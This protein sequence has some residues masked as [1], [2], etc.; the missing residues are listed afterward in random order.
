MITKRRWPW[1]GGLVGVVALGSGLTWLGL[2]YER[3]NAGTGPGEPA[4]SGAGATM[5]E[6]AVACF[7]HVDVKHG[8]TSLFPAQSG[9]VAEVLVEENQEV[10]AGTVLLRLEDT[11]SRLRVEEARADLEAARAQLVQTRKLPQQHQAQGAQAMAAIEVAQ[12]RLAS[13]RQVCDSKADLFAK[14]LL[15]HTE[16]DVARH[17]VKEAEAVLQAEQQKLTELKLHDAATDICR[18]EED[19]KARQARLGQALEALRECEL[20]APTDGKVLRI[21][22]GPGEMLGTRPG[23]AAI[24]FCPNGPRIIRAEVEQEFASRVKVGQQAVIR[25]DGND[26]TVWHGRVASLSDWYTHRR[27]ILQEPLQTN[28]VRTLEC[29]ITLG[30]DQAPMRIGQ[31]VRVL[32]GKKPCE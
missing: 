11:V 24:L 28:D 16:L 30:P 5:P 22:V 25:D 29:L 32:I 21:L 31:R 20:R 6:E 26:P 23:Q 15:K 2:C 4:P 27:S 8:V 7:G 19:V 9:R 18:A 10:K 14:Q 17:Q 13:A 3:V 12:E 1:V